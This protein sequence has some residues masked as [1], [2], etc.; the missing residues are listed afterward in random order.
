MSITEVLDVLN[1]AGFITF[2]IIG[3]TFLVELSKKLD[4]LVELRC[5]IDSIEYYLNHS[6]AKEKER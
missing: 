2:V 5:K 3:C 4:V 1:T 6:N